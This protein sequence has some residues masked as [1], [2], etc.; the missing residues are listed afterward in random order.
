MLW[1]LTVDMKEL[2]CVYGCCL[3]VVEDSFEE[4]LRG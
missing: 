3:G 4:D 2:R 1:D